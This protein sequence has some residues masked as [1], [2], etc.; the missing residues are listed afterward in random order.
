MK[1]LVHM[2]IHIR[3]IF[4]CNVLFQVPLSKCH[5][6]VPKE[7]FFHRGMDLQEKEAQKD[8]SIQEIC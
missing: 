6:I 5:V 4:N 7:L 2:V 8:Y 3:K 1:K